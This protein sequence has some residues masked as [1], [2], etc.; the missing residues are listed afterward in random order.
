[1]KITKCCVRSAQVHAEAGAQGRVEVIVATTRQT[2]DPMEEVVATKSSELLGFDE[3]DRM[4]DSRF[5]RD[6][7]KIISYPNLKTNSSI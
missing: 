7:R 5:E 2:L 1:M 6:I 4:L 3:A